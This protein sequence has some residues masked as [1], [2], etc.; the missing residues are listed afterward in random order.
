[1][2]DDLPK[3]SLQVLFVRVLCGCVV[4]CGKPLLV[5]VFPVLMRKSYI[6]HLDFPLSQPILYHDFRFCKSL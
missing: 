3:N 5:Y 1:M 4:A 2:C 6:D